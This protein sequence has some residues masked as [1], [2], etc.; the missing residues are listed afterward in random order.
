[1]L[2]DAQQNGEGVDTKR[3]SKSLLFSTDKLP[4]F[5][6]LT[7]GRHGE[8]DLPGATPDPFRGPVFALSR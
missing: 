1:M 2:G 4:R 8:A 7:T 3:P 6:L 5:E